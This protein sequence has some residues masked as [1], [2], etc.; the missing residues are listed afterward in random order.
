MKNE[1]NNKGY[2]LTELMIYMVLAVVVM[3]LVMNTMKSVSTQYVR[4]RE[5]TKMQTNG[6][7][8][9]S[10]L[11][12]DLINTG[13][14]YHITKTL[15]NGVVQYKTLPM[16]GTPEE[17][18]LLGS[19]TSKLVDDRALL[20]DDSAAS[21]FHEPR[22]PA[23]SLEIFRSRL[24]SSDLVGSVERVS[25]HMSTDTLFRVFS[26]CATTT[27]D[28]SG[29]IQWS[30]PDTIALIENVEAIQYQFSPNG[31]DWED[32]PSDDIERHLMKYIR[33][34]LL[35]KSMREADIAGKSGTVTVGDYEVTMD[36]EHLYRSYSEVVPIRNNGIIQE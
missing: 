17:T 11:S 15:T 28:G 21:F 24:V 30:D 29:D 6:R 31:V 2:T 5:V 18:F 34:E 23:D 9:I 7:D 20:P 14:K 32:D 13:F 27:L 26:E 8:V 1:E 3:T 4:G 19:Y 36:G 10:I 25:Y 16:V 12:R 22:T 33:V 35:I